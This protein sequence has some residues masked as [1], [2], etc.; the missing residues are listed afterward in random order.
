MLRISN[1]V[2]ALAVGAALACG[3]IAAAAAGP[4]GA[5]T[6]MALRE[7]MEQLGQDMQAVT[8]AI[9]VEDW[10]KVAELAPKIADHQAPPLAEKMR[11][12]AWLKTDAMK[13]RGYDRQVHGDAEAMSEAAKRGDGKAVIANF[14][15]VQQSCLACHE[16]FRKSFVAHFE[17][18]P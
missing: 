5:P 12:L 10:A 18:S 13:F 7:I 11:I 8:G 6:P 16:N 17:A 1:G 9:A 2:A 15:K 4:A 14:A 3:G